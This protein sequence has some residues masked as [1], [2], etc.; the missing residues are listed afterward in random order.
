MWSEITHEASEWKRRNNRELKRWFSDGLSACG[1]FWASMVTCQ[2]L[3]GTFGIY[4]S[5]PLPLVSLA[6]FGS[7]ATSGTITFALAPLL[8]AKISDSPGP[9]QLESNSLVGSVLITTASY[10]ALERNSFR[11]AFPSELLTIGAYARV[12]GSIAATTAAAGA[13]QRRRIQQLGRRFG[14]H[15]CGYRPLSNLAGRV[16]FIADHMYVN[17]PCSF[18]L[19]FRLC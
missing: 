13:G 18:N 7:V 9:K 4:A 6:G 8:A 10:A 2:H 16:K 1:V 14:C 5:S 11:T 19:F 15:H 17:I 3:I 12:R